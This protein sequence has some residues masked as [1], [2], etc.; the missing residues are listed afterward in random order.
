MALEVQ[1]ANLLMFLR[2]DPKSG[3]GRKDL[4]RL[5][6]YADTPT[7]DSPIADASRGHFRRVRAYVRSIMGEP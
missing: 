5:L 2:Y 4:A 1:L 3:L 6:Q 7:S